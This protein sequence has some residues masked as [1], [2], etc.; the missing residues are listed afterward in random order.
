[1]IHFTIIN[2]FKLRIVAYLFVKMAKQYP[3]VNF[4]DYTYLNAN[5]YLQKF[6]NALGRSYLDRATL[7]KLLKVI[8][9]DF[10]LVGFIVPDYKGNYAL[11]N[12]NT[13]NNLLGIDE[14][15]YEHTKPEH[16]K[17]LQILERYLERW[18]AMD[19]E[20]ERTDYEEE[21]EEDEMERVSRELI[22]YDNLNENKMGRKIYI[23]ES[24]Y[25]RIISEG[26][27]VA[28]YSVEPDKVKVVKEFLD[29]N[30]IKGGIAAIGEDG[31]P[32]TTPIVALKGTDGKPARNMSDKQAFEL[33][34]DKFGKIYSDKIQ[35]NKFLAQILKDWYYDRIS[36]QGL[37]SVNRY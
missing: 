32:S 24:Q 19:F 14:T 1:M 11:Y 5:G 13:L 16:N 21:P 34:K 20:K 7:T 15:G 12:K 10:K 2:T 31:Y 26:I 29:N 35:A 3:Y 9:K 37:L 18:E 4:H 6:R 33:L 17:Y 23:T 28:K 36:K 30:F 22:D 8:N 25:N 27:E